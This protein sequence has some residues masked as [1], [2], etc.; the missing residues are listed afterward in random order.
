VGIVH[1]YVSLP[2]GNWLM[3]RFIWIF[4]HQKWRI[5]HDITALGV[6]APLKKLVKK[7][8]Q[9]DS[10]NIPTHGNI[11]GGAPKL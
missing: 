10:W 1:G 4:N 8:T 7:N 2:E 3:K 5:G 6:R 9:S 11:Q